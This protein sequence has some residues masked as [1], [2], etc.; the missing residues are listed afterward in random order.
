VMRAV[1][2]VPLIKASITCLQSNRFDQA[3]AY[4]LINIIIFFIIIFPFRLLISY[5]TFA[6]VKKKDNTLY[7]ISINLLS[8]VFKVTV[9]LIFP[10]GQ[11]YLFTPIVIFVFLYV[12]GIIARPVTYYHK[13][14]SLQNA[15]SCIAFAC[16]LYLD[17]KI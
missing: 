8:E 13:E 11:N 7:F 3:F 4:S 12:I 17:N 5:N 14:Q 10:F 2:Y 16:I 9:A 1:I 15:I 6:F